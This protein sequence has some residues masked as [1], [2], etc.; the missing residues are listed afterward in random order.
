[1]ILAA[2]EQ[3]H[4]WEVETAGHDWRGLLVHDVRAAVVN[5]FT[6]VLAVG[7]A[8]RAASHRI[9]A[10]DACPLPVAPFM[11]CIPLVG[12]CCMVKMRA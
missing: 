3:A 9:K 5:N 2:E 8:D 11:A 10:V 6:R 12:I 7:E 1:L 4:K